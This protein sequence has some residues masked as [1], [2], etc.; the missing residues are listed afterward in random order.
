ML[1]SRNLNPISPALYITMSPELS[2]FLLVLI[3]QFSSCTD[4][5]NT[6]FLF[7]K[8]SLEN[9]HQ[10]KNHVKSCAV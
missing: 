6:Y 3:K 1:F 8:K 2:D 4:K 7:R 10:A 5:L 9:S